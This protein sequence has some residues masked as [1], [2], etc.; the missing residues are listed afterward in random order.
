MYDI[1]KQILNISGIPLIKVA[2]AHIY[3]D[4]GKVTIEQNAV[5]TT[6]QK[7]KIEIDSVKKFHHLYDGTIDITSRLKFG[8][9]STYQYVILGDVTL[10]IKFQFF[11]S[12]PR[13]HNKK[14]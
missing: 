11:R 4:S 2:D 12:G 14:G 6:L 7:A 9:V 10:T 3:P 5:M 13:P 1:P 8:G